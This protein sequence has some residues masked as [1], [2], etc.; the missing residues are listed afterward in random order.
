MR[1]NLRL[2]L[3]F[4]AIVVS[5]TLWAAV[6]QEIR[7]SGT[8]ISDGEPLPG[9]SVQI[10]GE[11]TGTITDMDGKYSISAPSDAILVYRFV[12][13]KTVEQ[14][15]N[16]RNMINVTLESDSKELDEV[17]VVA[18]ATAKKY[19]FTGA[20]STV[21]G[22]EIAKLQVASVSRAL[23]VRFRAYR[24]AQPVASPVRMRKSVSGVSVLSMLP[25]HRFMWWT[26]SL[27][28]VLSTPS[29]PMTL[30]R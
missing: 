28:M 20:A 3:T 23:E 5:A 16:G 25:V 1:I 24:P 18:Y 7:I 4:L 26:V 13:L 8:V 15:V 30:L 11:T 29:I 10:K 22:D 9:V 6:Q 14:S 19:S 12:G 2:V 17:M 27:S 21:K